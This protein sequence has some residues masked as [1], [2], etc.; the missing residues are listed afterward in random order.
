MLTSFSY[1]FSSHCYAFFQRAFMLF[2]SAFLYSFSVLSLVYLLKLHCCQLALCAVS[3]NRPLAAMMK[4]KKP[5]SKK[6]LEKL[7]WIGDL[8]DA[9]SEAMENTIEDWA[10]HIRG[11]GGWETGRWRKTSTLSPQIHLSPKD[12]RK[13]T[14]VLHLRERR[15]WSLYYYKGDGPT[16]ETLVES[17]RGHPLFGIGRWEK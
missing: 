17:F 12:A 1:S 8:S 15:H 5:P 2:F 3:C 6:H 7:E 13:K 14:G 16:I 11:K 4:K 10:A 9:D